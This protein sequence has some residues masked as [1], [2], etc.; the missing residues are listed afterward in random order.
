MFFS[1]K[2]KIYSGKTTKIIVRNLIFLNFVGV[3]SQQSCLK[4]NERFKCLFNNLEFFSI[5][6]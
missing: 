1:N 5:L 4:Y 2:K 3:V 6:T